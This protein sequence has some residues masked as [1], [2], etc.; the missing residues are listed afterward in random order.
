MNMRPLI[1]LTALCWTLINGG[2]IRVESRNE[3]RETMPP[4]LPALPYYLLS[5]F[6]G[7]RELNHTGDCRSK[8]DGS[9]DFRGFQVG[10]NASRRVHR[11]CPSLLQSWLE[12]SCCTSLSSSKP[13][14]DGLLTASSLPCT[15]LFI[16][17]TLIKA[18]YSGR[19]VPGERTPGKWTR[20][21]HGIF[22]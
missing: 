7:P 8:K 3:G 11:P 5:T 19:L 14:S 9:W 1:F 13:S 12:A 20:R 4:A 6:R 10:S 16:R 21:P 2:V 22:T 15:G 17:M 18:T